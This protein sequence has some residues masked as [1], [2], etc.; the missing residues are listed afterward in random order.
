MEIWDS[1]IVDII[2]VITTSTIFIDIR[3]VHIITI[4]CDDVKPLGGIFL[5]HII[6]N[7]VTVLVGL[8]QQGHE[9]QVWGRFGALA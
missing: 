9:R 8:V 4:N 3:Y 6:E 2:G 7:S 5:P 1:L